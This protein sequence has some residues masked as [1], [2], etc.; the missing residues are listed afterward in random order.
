MYWSDFLVVKTESHGLYGIADH[1]PRQGR[2]GFCCSTRSADEIW[3]EDMLLSRQAVDWTWLGVRNT[4]YFLLY[5]ADFWWSVKVRRGGVGTHLCLH[6]YFYERNPSWKA[7][8]EEEDRAEEGRREDKQVKDTGDDVEGTAYSGF[9]PIDSR[10]LSSLPL[11]RA[12]VLKLLQASKNHIHP[13]NNM[14]VTI[15]SSCLIFGSNRLL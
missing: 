6:K 7:I 3:P 4:T 1:H 13:S 15:V 12:R 9:T 2:R 11:V 14:L 5:H 8:R 10:H